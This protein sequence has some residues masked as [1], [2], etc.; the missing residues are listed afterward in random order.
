MYN[1]WI[2]QAKL[3]AHVAPSVGQFS[4][5]YNK[6][7]F[8]GGDSARDT[9][10]ARSATEMFGTFT[11]PLGRAWICHSIDLAGDQGVRGYIRID[12]ISTLAAA[13]GASSY[14]QLY[15]GFGLPV[16]QVNI[17]LHD[18][19]MYEQSIIRPTFVTETGVT[20]LPFSSIGLHV[21][22]ITNDLRFDAPYVIGMMGHSA[23]HT[24][25]GDYSG[26]AVGGGKPRGEHLAMFRV[27]DS[28]RA[29]GIDCRLFNP[30]FGGASAAQWCAFLRQGRYQSTKVDVW[31]LDTA[32]NDVGA[33]SADADA[34]QLLWE[35]MMRWMRRTSPGCDIILH[36]MGPSDS[37]EKIA[38]RTFFRDRLAKAQSNFGGTAN[39]VYIADLAT[40]FS[41][42]SSTDFAN[43]ESAGSKIHPNI[44]GQRGYAEVIRPV[45]TTTRF[46]KEHCA[47][48]SSL[49][50]QSVATA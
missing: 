6:L 5:G 18:R 25:P 34:A 15:L 9:V 43:T 49:V 33:T 42:T 12:E 21:T 46:F 13:S 44:D 45:Y 17:P 14:E 41:N 7:D 20:T 32:F 27:R 47:F 4:A 22:Q 19:V 23:Y 48:S 10:A 50:E 26:V 16:G 11:V 28:L 31:H 38:K 2:Q 37:A 24:I 29:A 40:A 1:D 35:E 30:S 39:G 3:E 8:T 36:Q